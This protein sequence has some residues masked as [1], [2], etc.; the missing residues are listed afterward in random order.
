MSKSENTPTQNSGMITHLKTVDSLRKKDWAVN[1][2]SYYYDNV[3]DLVKE[4]DIVAEKQ[5][6]TNQSARIASSQLNIQLFIECKYINQGI[7]FWFDE[8]NRKKA[9][10][11]VGQMTDLQIAENSSGDISADSFHYLRSKKAAKLF[12][13]NQN[14][15]DVIYKAISQSLRAQVYYEQW[16]SGPVTFEFNDHAEV[17]TKI[18]RYPIVI[19]DNFSKLNEVDSSTSNYPTKKIT[20]SF[21]LETNYIYFTKDKTMTKDD[22]FLV[23]VVDIDKFIPFLEILEKEAAAILYSQEILNHREQHRAHR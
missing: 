7:V 15:E 3:A 20:D 10:D 14:N 21:L 12:S 4:I 9:I 2:S 1:I 8:L 22:Y 11:K 13:G 23:D 19:C 6:N 17:S 16:A 18:V 5:F